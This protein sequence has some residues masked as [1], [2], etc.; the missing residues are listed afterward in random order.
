MKVQVPPDRRFS[1]TVD[2]DGFI[3]RGPEKT[4]I[5]IPLD[6]PAK[7]RFF[8]VAIPLVEGMTG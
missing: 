1:M 8:N 2:T 4:G 6:V 7:A 5:G 3:A